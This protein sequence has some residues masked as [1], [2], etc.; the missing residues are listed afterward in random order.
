MDKSPAK[1]AEKTEDAMLKLI[2]IAIRNLLRYKRRTL[3]TTSLIAIGITFVLVFISASGAFKNLMIGQITDAMLGHIQVHRRGYVGSIDS[4]PLTMNLNPGQMKKLEKALTE[5]PGIEAYS[6][7]IR[8]AGMFSN[9]MES[10]NIRIYGIDPEKETAV[11]PLL[12]GRVKKGSNS[13]EKGSLF[14]PELLANGMKVKVG[15]TIVVIATNRD[16]SVNGKQFIVG[17]IIDSVTGPGG[18]DGYMHIEDA[19]EV[20]RLEQTEVSEVA[21]R[22]KDFNRLEAISA[23]LSNAL[24]D[25]T[26][27]QGKAMFDVRTWEDLSPFSNVARMID[28]MTFFI[29]LMLISIVLVSIMNVMIMAVFERIRE[30]GTIAAIGTKPGKILSLFLIEGLALGVVGSILGILITILATW[31]INLSRISFNFGRQVGL[32]LSPRLD[33]IDILVISLIVI[34]VSVAAA[35]HPAIKASRM[36]PINALRHI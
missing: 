4:L 20:L 16:G 18:R 30:I 7:R 10:T 32:I 11:I 35:L 2:K 22:L 27:A 15:D 12:P 36:E 24:K 1:P 29:K 6:P 26:N 34:A 23:Q 21:L 13:L 3:L 31:I 28:I 5:I 19:K 17:A 25:E 14:I 8:F 33:P 9:F